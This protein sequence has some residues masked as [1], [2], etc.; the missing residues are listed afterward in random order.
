MAS[1]FENV[2]FDYPGAS[3]FMPMDIAKKLHYKPGKCPN[4]SLID[5]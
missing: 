1:R 5:I 3:M 2:Y 4:I